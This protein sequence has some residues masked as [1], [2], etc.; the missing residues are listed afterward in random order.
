VTIAIGCATTGPPLFAEKANYLGPMSVGSSYVYERRNSGSFGSD[1]HLRPTKALG[2]KTWQGQKL[3]ASEAKDF[4]VLSEPSSG[5]WVA[6]VREDKTILSFDPPQGY[7]YPIWVGKTWTEAYRITNHI[8]G[9]TSNVEIRFSV[10]AKEEI[11]VPAGTYKVFRVTW[12]YTDGTQEDTSWHSPELG[13]FI[14]YKSQRTAK[15]PMGP[16]VQYTELFSHD[17]RR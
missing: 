7:T 10:E 8:T 15:H 12:N 13:I 4:T 1:T 16:G 3:N 11:K 5:K 6:I 17:I 14:K 2:E 9:K